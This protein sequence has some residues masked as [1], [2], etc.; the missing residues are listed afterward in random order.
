MCQDPVLTPLTA[1]GVAPAA[2]LNDASGIGMNV[3]PC[4]CIHTDMDELRIGIP[5][6]FRL[7]PESTVD[8]EHT[9]GYV[10]GFIGNQE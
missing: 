6:A 7:T 8:I 4:V 2:T 9:A 5:N 10:I 3:R 1:A